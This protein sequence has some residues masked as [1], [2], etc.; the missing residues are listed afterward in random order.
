MNWK[1]VVISLVSIAGL[2]ILLL[3]LGGLLMDWNTVI[4]AIPRWRAA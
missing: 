1:T 2:T 3:T 4:V